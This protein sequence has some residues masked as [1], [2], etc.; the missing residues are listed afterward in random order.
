MLIN[1]NLCRISH[2]FGDTATYWSKIANSYPPHP[3][4][5][6]SLRVIPFEFW[7]KG[8]KDS[9]GKEGREGEKGK[10]REG[11]SGREGRKGQ[12]RGKGQEKEGMG[13]GRRVR[14][15]EEGER[16]KEDCPWEHACQI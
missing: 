16:R 5:T 4:A 3:H 11:G 14:D 15:R 7:D 1:S 10:R 2:R 6:P 12:S 13:E 9:K 8:G